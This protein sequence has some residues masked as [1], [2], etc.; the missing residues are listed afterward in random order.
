MTDIPVR[1]PT[2][3][4]DPSRFR[5]LM[6]TFPTGVSIVTAAESSGR[7]WGMTCSSVCSVAVDPPTLL[8]CLR[9]DS[10]TLDATL[11]Q[12]VFAVNLLPE[13]AR[14]VAELF[15]SGATD[16]FERTRW[17]FGSRS[18]VPHLVADAHAIADCRVSDTVKVGDH[19]VVFGEV[20]GVH[21]MTADPPDPL[22]YGLRGYSSW[23]G[24]RP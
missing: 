2:M 20:F 7:P 5:S 18:G 15:A 17:E 21:E 11:L 9:A 14:R 4:V 22:L 19:T 24:R 10:P 1:V 6:A 8:V 16:R 3:T 13:R 12:S 23:S